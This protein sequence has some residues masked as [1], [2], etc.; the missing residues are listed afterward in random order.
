MWSPKQKK[1][2][3]IKEYFISVGGGG[4][5]RDFRR[6]LTPNIK[7][8]NVTKHKNDGTVYIL[9]SFFSELKKRSDLKMQFMFIC[10]ASSNKSICQILVSFFSW[11]KGRQILYQ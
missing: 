1:K 6:S 5:G 11:A 8:H 2:T 3:S 7:I 10:N 4:K 9:M